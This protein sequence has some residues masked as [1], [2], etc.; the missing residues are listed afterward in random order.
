MIGRLRNHA[1]FAATKQ[2]RLAS[3]DLPE[4]LVSACL[5]NLSLSYT[6]VMSADGSVPMDIVPSADADEA[7]EEEVAATVAAVMAAMA[8]QDT[9][10]SASSTQNSGTDVVQFQSFDHPPT[11]GDAAAADDSA[12]ILDVVVET[13]Q[14]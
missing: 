3:N 2:A 1:A 7:A 11:A 6:Q 8:A 10:M 13:Q 4:A 14:H 9:E 5:T 12:V